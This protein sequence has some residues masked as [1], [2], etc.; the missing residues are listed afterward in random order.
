MSN[1]IIVNYRGHEIRY[2]HNADEWMCS[3]L[4]G[5]YITNPR[6]SKVKERIDK[7]YLDIRKKNAV[8]VVEVA[9]LSW[10]S[11]DEAIVEGMVVEYLGGSK[12]AVVSQRMG[13]KKASRAERQLKDVAPDTPE[14]REAI[15]EYL[16]AHEETAKARR[17]ED[18]MFDKIPRLSI[19][20][21]QKLVDIHVNGD[22]EEEDKT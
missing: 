22:T 13:A 16:K 10:F 20:A 9:K 17:V 14:V 8:P 1:E 3:E 2:N 11:R 5:G 12:I 7:M 6:L 18:E 21:I 15:S 4:D 19:H